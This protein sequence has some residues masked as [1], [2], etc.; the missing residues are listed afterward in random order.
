MKSDTTREALNRLWVI[1]NY[2]L[3]NYLADAPPAWTDEDVAAAALLHDISEDQRHMA[4]RIGKM[5]IAQGGKLPLGMFPDRFL[6]WNDLAPRFMLGELVDYQQRTIA[7]IDKL[8]SQLP[9]ASIAKS[10]AQECLGVAK[11]H[12]DSLREVA[13]KKTPQAV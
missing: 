2:S 10:L 12:L 13:A 3:A 9:Q 11:A 5:I 8:I 4:D 1:H 7:A 6:T